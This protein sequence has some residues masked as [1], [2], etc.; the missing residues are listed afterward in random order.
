MSI[1]I[2]TIKNTTK[3]SREYD[4][5]KEFP[6]SMRQYLSS[7]KSQFDK[8]YFNRGTDQEARLASTVKYN[9]ADRDFGGNNVDISNI[10]YGI[11]N[12]KALQ[13]IIDLYIFERRWVYHPVRKFENWNKISSIY[14]NSEEYYWLILLFNRI[15]NPFVDL[16]NFNIVRIPNYSFLGEIPSG[17][18]FNFTGGDF[19]LNV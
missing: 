8:M 14:Y 1:S 19:K 6:L 10:F 12:C 17:F 7:G 16:Q 18:I 15:V 4:T 13:D 11:H 3:Q 5:L 9:V 2:S